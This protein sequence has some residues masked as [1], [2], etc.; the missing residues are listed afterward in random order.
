[1][2]FGFQPTQVPVLAPGQKQAED[3]L[4]N[5]AGHGILG[6]LCA[7]LIVALFFAIKG[8]LRSKDERLDDQKEMSK[9]LTGVNEGASKLAIESNRAVDTVKTSLDG[10]TKG[11]SK[12]EDK[13]EDLEKQ[14]LQ[15]VAALPAK[16]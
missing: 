11:V 2:A 14:Q 4:S 13:L 9:A 5:I 15:L 1:M 8:W 3:A 12:L 6:S 7:L 16:R 10:L